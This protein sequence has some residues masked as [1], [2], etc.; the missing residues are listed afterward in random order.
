MILKFSLLIFLLLI[1]LLF[2]TSTKYIVVF[3]TFFP[4]VSNICCHIIVLFC[5]CYCFFAL[6][7]GLLQKND[8]FIVAA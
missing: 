8:F 4:R 5:Y 2:N 1:F 3:V 7:L 6:F